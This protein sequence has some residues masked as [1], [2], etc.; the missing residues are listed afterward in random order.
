VLLFKG[1]AS[2]RVG[3]GFAPQDRRVRVRIMAGW[4]FTYVYLWSEGGSSGDYH[5]VGQEGEEQAKKEIARLGRDGWEPVGEVVFQYGSGQKT[6][7]PQL[8]LKRAVTRG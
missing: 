8:M 5:S 3:V 6:V 2:G 7:V 4:E 1:R